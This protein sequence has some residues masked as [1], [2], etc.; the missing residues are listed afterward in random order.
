ML[1]NLATFLRNK[2][3]S[4]KNFE[5]D[6]VLQLQDFQLNQLLQSK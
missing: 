6:I 1:D 3:W 2:Y 5:G 4:E